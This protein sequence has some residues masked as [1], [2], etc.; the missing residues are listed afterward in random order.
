MK[1]DKE[2]IQ[3]GEIRKD[4]KGI[5]GV[6]GRVNLGFLIH[7]LIVGWSS[8]IILELKVTLRTSASTTSFL[9]DKIEPREKLLGE[10]CSQS[11]GKK[12]F[13]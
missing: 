3:P 4:F 7:H 9:D 5:K 12:Y 6:T 11:L 10:L 2:E 8:Q 1:V 13:I